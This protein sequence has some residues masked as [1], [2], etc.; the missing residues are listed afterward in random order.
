L[1]STAWFQRFLFVLLPS[2][3]LSRNKKLWYIWKLIKHKLNTEIEHKQIRKHEKYGACVHEKKKDRELIFQRLLCEKFITQYLS[4]LFTK[5]H[6][7]TALRKKKEAFV[8]K[9]FYRLLPL[10]SCK[11]AHFTALLVIKNFS[12]LVYHIIFNILLLP[13]AEHFSSPANPWM[14]MKTFFK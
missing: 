3:F 1:F 11:N 9:F 13:H 8:E 14:F 10:L 4:S 7:F 2:S 5:Q 12:S 6:Q